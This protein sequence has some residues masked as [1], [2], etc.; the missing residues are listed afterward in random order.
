MGYEKLLKVTKEAIEELRRYACRRD[1]N[2]SEQSKLDLCLYCML[3]HSD[4]STHTII[5]DIERNLRYIEYSIRSEVFRDTVKRCEKE[6]ELVYCG[7]DY[8][9]DEPDYEISEHRQRVLKTLS[10]LALVVKTPDYFKEQ[11]L[12]YDK[13]EDITSEIDAFCDTCVTCTDFEII[14]KLAEMGIVDKKDED[15]NEDDNCGCVYCGDTGGY[16]TY[17]D[18]MGC[19]CTT[20]SSDGGTIDNGFISTTTDNVDVNVEQTKE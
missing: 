11:E 6:G 13:M 18:A 9:S 16:V 3:D 2:L 7:W 12:F 10:T 1:E 15:E 8:S 14:G 19:D 5:S 4:K 20:T 17:G